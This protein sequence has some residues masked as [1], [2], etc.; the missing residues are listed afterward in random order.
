MTSLSPP[1]TKLWWNEP[2]EMSE[3]IWITI[4]FFWGLLMTFMMPFWHVTGNQNLS[5]ETYKIVPEQFLEKAQAM[6]DKY[7]VRHE[8][9]RKYAVVRPPPGGD[10]YIVA[11]LWEFWPIVE[12]KKNETYRF[13]LSSMDW[14]HGFS[15]QPANINIQVVPKYEHVVSFTPNRAGEYS[16]LCNEYCG[17]GHH[18]MIGKLKVVE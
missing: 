18:T 6:V 16:I 10:V 7:T 11:R 14:Q 1:K 15:L 17:I 13:H 4:V 5:T 9:P 2:I 3:L 12:L 8:G